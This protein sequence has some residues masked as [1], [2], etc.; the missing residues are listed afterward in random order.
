V[1]ERVHRAAETSFTRLDIGELLAGHVHR[2]ERIEI[3]VGIDPDGV[4]LLFGDRALRLRG[5]RNDWTKKK[6]KYKGN[7]L[8]LTGLSH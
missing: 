8:L 5:E 2:H 6:S 7:R 3:N 1:S 4:G